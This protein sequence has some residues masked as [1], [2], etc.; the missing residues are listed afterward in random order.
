MTGPTKAKIKTRADRAEAR[1]AAQWKAFTAEEERNAEREADD[2]AAATEEEKK[3]DTQAQQLC[4]IAK[5]TGLFH[6]P[7]GTGYAD[8]LIGGH[9]ETYPIRSKAFRSWVL[10]QFY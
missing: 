3:R 7:D 4:K 6:T 8:V 1:C 5:A 2:A 10:R 9:R